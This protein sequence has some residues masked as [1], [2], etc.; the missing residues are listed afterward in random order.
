LKIEITSFANGS[1]IADNNCFCIPLSDGRITFGK[2]INPNI[3]W[4]D[5]PVT[6][7]SF[8]LICVD[9]DVPSVGDDVNQEG[10]IVPF[11]LPRVEF[12][13]WVIANIPFNVNEIIEGTDSNGITE[14]GKIPGISDY[15]ASIGINDYTNWFAGDDKMEGFYGGYDGPCPPWND[16]RIHHYHF[17]VF[18]LDCE[19]IEISG[20]FTGRDL[21]KAIENHIVDQAEY[22]GTYTL[23]KNLLK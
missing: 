18:A 4:S 16:E 14:R 10:K 1:R 11:D 9:P 8:A 20:N 19:K 7:K 3:K 2:N 15:G 21:L 13:H 5:F 12:F 6:T 23:N 22:I 17:K